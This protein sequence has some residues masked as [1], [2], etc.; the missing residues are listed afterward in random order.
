LECPLQ[1]GAAFRQI[2]GAKQLGIEF[3]AAGAKAGALQGAIQNL[4]ANGLSSASVELKQFSAQFKE[5]ALNSQIAQELKAS[6]MDLASGISTAFT[7]AISGTQ[8][9]GES[10]ASALLSTIGDLAIKL[11]GIILTS[12]L[13]I[14]ALSTSLKSFTGLPAIAAGIG[15]LAI[16]GIAKGAV[17]NLGKT[18]TGSSPIGSPAIANYGQKSNQTTI[19]VLAEFKLRGQDLTAIGRQQNYRSKITD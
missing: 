16:G 6:I 8:G 2:D 19:K 3:D 10:I 13:G 5:L 4:L 14:E 17:A 1:P 7:D 15:L 18:G 9:F 12:G 11:G